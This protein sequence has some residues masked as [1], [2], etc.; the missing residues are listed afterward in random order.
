[1][2]GKS[3]TGEIEAAAGDSEHRE[4]SW[5]AASVGSTPGGWSQAQTS[6]AATTGS[7]RETGRRWQDSWRSWRQG[8]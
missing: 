6:R 8:C 2:T 4:G 1:V 7:V 3:F 5:A